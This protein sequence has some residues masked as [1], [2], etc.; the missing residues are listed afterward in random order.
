M[1]ISRKQIRKI[2]RETMGAGSLPLSR[3]AKEWL[4]WGEGYGLSPEEDNDGQ[5][6]FYFDLEDDVDGSIEREATA[7]GGDVVGSYDSSSVI[8]YT[9]EYTSEIDLGPEIQ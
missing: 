2:I 1:K 4:A 9:N 7:M 8:I 6:L 5:L 3:K